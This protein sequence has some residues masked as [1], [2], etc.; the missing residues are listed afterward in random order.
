MKIKPMYSFRLISFNTY[1]EEESSSKDGEEMQQDSFKEKEYKVQMFGIN[2]KGETASIIVEGF[3]PYFY[4]KVENDWDQSKMLAFIAQVKQEVGPYYEKSIL[5]PKFVK[6]NKL[7]GF[8]GGEKHTFILMKFQNESTM[9]KVKNLWYTSAVKKG[10]YQRTLNPDGY[11]CKENSTSTYLYEAQIPPL[12]RLFHI[13]DISPSGW[14]SL[15]TTKA[16]K[17]PRKNRKTHCTH[18]FMI[19]YKHNI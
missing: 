5:Q 7:Y 1:D 19:H 10:V 4:V 8:D 16:R 17:M 9:R 11:V 14:I 15:P 6:K 3:T 2:D 18:E 12:L 13:K